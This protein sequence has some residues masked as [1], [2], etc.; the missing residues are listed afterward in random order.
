M[1]TLIIIILNIGLHKLL[2]VETV[3]MELNLRLS[4]AN[5][6]NRWQ[7]W[8]DS[9]DVSKLRNISWK[10][11]TLSPPRHARKMCYN[12][13]LRWNVFS[14]GTRPRIGYLGMQSSNKLCHG[15]T[16][17]QSPSPQ[18]LASLWVWRFRSPRSRTLQTFS[19]SRCLRALWGR[20]YHA[21]PPLWEYWS[22]ATPS[23]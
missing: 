8:K 7:N 14:P 6:S 10:S 15:R 1:V 16:L 17:S 13:G 3:S 5:Q 12:N 23:L 18:N 19:Q 21:S 2:R 11:T 20:G 22:E 4:F 9:I